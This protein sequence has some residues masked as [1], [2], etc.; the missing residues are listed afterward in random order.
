MGT[1]VCGKVK[2]R[3]KSLP[4]FR[5]VFHKGEMESKHTGHVTALRC[6]GNWDVFML[7]T[8]H[9]SQMGTTRARHHKSNAS[10]IRPLCLVE[11]RNNT[12]PA[13]EHT[14]IR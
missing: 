2:K 14:D 1:H 4:R 10:T 6:R 12:N 3:V 7:I 8:F 11:Y 13:T 9:S 5:K